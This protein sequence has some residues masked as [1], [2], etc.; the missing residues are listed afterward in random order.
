MCYGFYGGYSQQGAREQKGSR[1]HKMFEDRE[2]AT[3]EAA[4]AGAAGSC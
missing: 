3:A 4:D 1:H 2:R